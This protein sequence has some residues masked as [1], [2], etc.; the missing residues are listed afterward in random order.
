MKN[1]RIVFWSLLMIQL[2]ATLVANSQNQVIQTSV[3]NDKELESFLLEMGEITPDNEFL[4]FE[5]TL[6][7]DNGFC[8]TAF[9]L[10]G[11]HQT[12]FLSYYSNEG[13]NFIRR[14]EF[15]HIY[16]ELKKE[17]RFQN[18]SE[19]ERLRLIV[20]IATFLEVRLEQFRYNE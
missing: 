12:R 6:F 17:T 10:M 2:T 9:G 16:D 5:D 13:R 19:T 18:I 1:E 7:Q 8:L 3:Q 11:H 20:E 15:A 4:V 14:Y